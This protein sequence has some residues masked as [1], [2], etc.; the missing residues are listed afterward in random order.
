[1]TT[2]TITELPEP[3]AEDAL[4]IIDLNCWIWRFWATVQGRCAHAFIEFIGGILRNHRPVHVAACRDLP[5]P[6]FRAKLYPKREDTGEGYKAQRE[7]PDPTLLERIRWAAEML[8]DVYGIPV[9][10]AIGF[11]ADD[12][13]AA[14]TQQAKDAGMRVVILAKDKDLMQLV[15]DRCVLW[16]GKRTVTGPREV[17]AKF[18]IRA[19]QL[20]DYLAIVGDTA[21]NVPGLHGAGPKAAVELL[22]E[23]GTL[24]EAL[25]CASAPYDRPFYTHRPRYRAM[26]KAQRDE[27]RLSQ[28]LVSLAFDA[29][30]T[31]QPSET[32]R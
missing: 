14:L 25:A 22:R 17:E 15:D 13:I 2:T 31:F 21:D 18:G 7:P 26:L 27:V 8:Q 30:V 9:Y 29:P 6:T 4:L 11:E 23:F 3:E 20:R 12:L 32:R 24:D 1:M 10:S 19:D 28:K 5:H 16:D